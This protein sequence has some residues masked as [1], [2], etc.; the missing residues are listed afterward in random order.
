[1]DGLGAATEVELMV[2]SL[3]HAAVVVVGRILRSEKRGEKAPQRTK[4]HDFTYI[5]KNKRV[6]NIHSHSR[7]IDFRR[8]NRPSGE[9]DGDHKG[10]EEVEEGFVDFLE[11]ED[12]G[13]EFGPA[14]APGEEDVVQVVV[15]ACD[16]EVIPLFFERREGEVSVLGDRKFPMGRKLRTL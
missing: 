11:D 2:I 3:R 13:A 15:H 9:G 8:K 16:E 10:G 4:P 12:F 1:M 7:H 6:D 14:E 5:I